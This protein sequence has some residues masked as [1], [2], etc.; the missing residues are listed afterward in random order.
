MFHPFSHVVDFDLSHHDVILAMRTTCT[1]KLISITSLCRGYRQGLNLSY[2]WEVISAL[3]TLLQISHF[4]LLQIRNVTRTLRI[5]CWKPSR[6]WIFII[7]CK[8][9]QMVRLQRWPQG[10]N[11][12]W[13][14]TS[15]GRWSPGAAAYYQMNYLNCQFV[16]EIANIFSKTF[17][18]NVKNLFSK[19]TEFCIF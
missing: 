3:T 9:V 1:Q 5:R 12:R 4:F 19:C 7:F 11:C 10:P 14:R 13:D 17:F 6:N 16:F 18:R 15:R 8:W 2:Y